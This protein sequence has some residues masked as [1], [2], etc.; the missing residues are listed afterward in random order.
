MVLLSLLMFTKS[1]I[2]VYTLRSL[3]DSMS[4]VQYGAHAHKGNIPNQN[5]TS[6]FRCG[7]VRL[8]SHSC[9]VASTEHLFPPTHPPLLPNPPTHTTGNQPFH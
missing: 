5:T 9:C 1:R 6:R 3:R 4:A 2:S 8:T 7:P